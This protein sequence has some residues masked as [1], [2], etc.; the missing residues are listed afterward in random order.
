VPGKEKLDLTSLIVNILAFLAIAVFVH[1]EVRRAARLCQIAAVVAGILPAFF[2]TGN[3]A[4]VEKR[5]WLLCCAVLCAPLLQLL[6]ALMVLLSASLLSITQENQASNIQVVLNSVALGFVLEVDNKMGDMIASQ[7]TRLAAS[8][9]PSQGMFKSASM[10]MREC[11]RS[12]VLRSCMGHAYFALAGLMLTQEPVLLSPHATMLLTL[13]VLAGKG[14]TTTIELLSRLAASSPWGSYVLPNT[15]LVNISNLA[16]ATSSSPYDDRW[17]WQ[18]A[19]R[20]LAAVRDM[21]PNK[22]FN[23]WPEGSGMVT[24]VYMLLLVGQV[25]LLYFKPLLSASRWW[26]RIF[27]VLQPLTAVVAAGYAY[28][29]GRLYDI[30][31]IF[32]FYT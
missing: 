7:Q 27:L 3:T 15:V 21:D 18:N 31:T 13:T 20:V 9:A 16:R 30:I 19:L 23:D 12:S 24:V 22:V 10:S 28:S 14:P 6:T 25:L 17:S 29:I 11:C 26:S 4:R 2:S 8:R 1:D 32:D 5:H